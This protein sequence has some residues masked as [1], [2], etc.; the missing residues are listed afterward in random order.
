MP[1]ILVVDDDKIF[2]IMLRELLESQGYDV[3]EAA[4]SDDALCVFQRREID[5]I[6]TDLFLPPNG[7]L[8]VIENVRKLDTEVS[9][10]VVSGMSLNNREIIFNQARQRGA[11]QTLGKPVDPDTFKRLIAD[12]L[13]EPR[14]S[15]SG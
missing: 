11:T 14:G 10:V 8:Y 1:R 4:T 12:L 9:I 2:R 6:I 3:L 5:L 7:G 15:N 13:A